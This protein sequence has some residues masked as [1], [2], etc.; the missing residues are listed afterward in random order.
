MEFPKCSAESKTSAEPAETSLRRMRD[1][2]ETSQNHSLVI[3][4]PETLL[5]FETCFLIWFD[6]T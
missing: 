1:E 2:F 4:H 5:S 3:S 6:L